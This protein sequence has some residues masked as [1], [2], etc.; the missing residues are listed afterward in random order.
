MKKAISILILMTIVF[1]CLAA[2]ADDFSVRNGIKFGMTKDEVIE[3]E[4][5]NGFTEY[6]DPKSRRMRT[7]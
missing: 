5:Q 4:K 7:Q 3:T 6:L 2:Y 1:T